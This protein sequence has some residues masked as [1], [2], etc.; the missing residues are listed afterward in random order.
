MPE[1]ATGHELQQFVC[2][3]DWM[4][5]VIPQF[6]SLIQHLSSRR[7]L[8]SFGQ[9]LSPSRKQSTAFRRHLGTTQSSA[10]NAI[11][12]ALQKAAILAHPDSNKALCLFTDASGDH[13]SDVLTQIPLNDG[14]SDFVNQHHEL[15]RVCQDHLKGSSSLW[16]TPEKEA[17]LAPALLKLHRICFL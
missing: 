3:A 6:T 15:F 9:S 14:D 8:Q 12:L 7:R 13:W 11:T 10:F 2:T 4:R 16:S 17:L 1:P 5:S